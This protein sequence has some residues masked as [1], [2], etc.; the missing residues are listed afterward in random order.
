[1]D[2]QRACLHLRIEA[3]DSLE[4]VLARQQP[5]GIA[6]QQLRQLVLA[7]GQ[8]HHLAMQ[9]HAAGGRVEF[10]RL[11][12]QQAGAA[13]TLGAA[14]ERLQACQQF[15]AARWFDQKIVGPVAKRFH[16]VAFGVAAGQKQNRRAVLQ[17]AQPVEHLDTG[18]VGQRPVEHQHIEGL[19]HHGLQ[20]TRA[21][22][23]HL[24]AVTAG[25]QGLGDQQ[26]V[27]DIVLQY[28]DPHRQ[29]LPQLAPTRNRRRPAS[30]E[31]DRTDAFR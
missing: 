25:V 8:V 15:R 3:P 9:A 4:Q 21:G 5:P 7:L 28:S 29:W 27:V 17:L 23:I 22:A 19:A 13:V 26:G 6:K 11:H 16:D 30:S 14:F 12:G 1:M 2:I 31:T 10:I 24:G 20:E 18:H